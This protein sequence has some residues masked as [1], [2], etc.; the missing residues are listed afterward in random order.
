MKV[1][2]AAPEAQTLVE[3]I[4]WETEPLTE[5]LLTTALSSEEVGSLLE[6][7]LSCH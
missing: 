6:T 3:L 5:P 4:N 2:S 1:G 7:P